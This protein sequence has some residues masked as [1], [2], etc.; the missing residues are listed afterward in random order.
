MMERRGGGCFG[1]CS[2]LRRLSNSKQPK[3]KTPNLSLVE[4]RKGGVG[5]GTRRQSKRERERGKE[6]GE[7]GHLQSERRDRP[8][9]LSGSSLADKPR[10]RESRADSHPVPGISL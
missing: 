2:P 4:G 10:Q 1:D 5:E 3:Q 9:A 7:I 6:M 8:W